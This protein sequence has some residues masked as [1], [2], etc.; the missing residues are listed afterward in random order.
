M[1]LLA[2]VAGC[3]SLD[4][5]NKNAPE[6]ERA[7]SDPQTIV[8][9]AAGTMKSYINLRVNYEPALAP[10]STQADEHS[11]SWNNFQSRYYSSYGVE[12][13]ERCGWENNTTG[14]RY[15]PLPFWWYGSYAVVSAAND[16]L[17]A[18]R[19]SAAPPDLGT[20][21]PWV[22]A[23]AQM[24]QGLG[25]GLVALTYDQGFVV[26]ESAHTVDELAALQLVS[27]TEVRDAAL[28][29][30]D[31]AAVLAAAADFSAAP[32]TLFGLPT[33]PRY[34]SAQIVQIIRTFEAELLAMF[35]RT[36]DEDAAVPWARVVSYA[37][38]GISSGTAFN[39]E[40]FQGNITRS[41]YED[42]FTGIDQWGNDY[43]TT[44]IDTRVARLLSTT[45][46]DPWPGG[47][48]N[49]RPADGLGNPIGGVYGVDR[50][51]GDGCF[52]A[53]ANRFG[54]G[55]CKA[56]A[57]SGT[58][59]MWSPSADFPASRGQFHQSNIGY[60]RN[61]CL[62]S[63]FDDCPNGS[64][65]FVVLSKYA[66]DLLWAEGLLRTTGPS[67]T[68]AALINNSHVGRG[69]LLPVSAVDTKD[70][71]LKALFYEWHAE[72]VSMAPDHFWNAR[73]LTKT[74]LI[75]AG[76]NPWAVN[77]QTYEPEGAYVW[78]PLWGGTPRSMPIPAKDLILLRLELYTFGG[79]SDP[80]GCGATGGPS[81]SIAA[82]GP[83]VKNVRQIYA[84]LKAM[85]PKP[86]TRLRQ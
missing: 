11:F 15:E 35:P 59:F 40:A 58:D 84:D 76:A 17:F 62:V 60:I 44:R 64:G 81:C 61:H 71:L 82:D 4:I 73:R 45:Q 22:E 21:A 39:F 42:F 48:G 49:P 30:L 53:V 46:Q 68:V 13:P 83:A 9:T 67:V 24:A 47:A 7:F 1:A 69:G 36:A 23:V 12:C 14:A 18:I 77:Q 66:N 79:P 5:V 74:S 72:L 56:T 3:P 75:S 41:G 19:K 55:E 33:G 10:F 31:S 63:G 38:R 43:T 27:R 52:G 86:G 78:N 28:A 51:L 80:L 8:A 85:M 50:R 57:N 37:S 25:H 70:N 34:T 20:D 2:G 6:R 54:E 29:Q 16:V 65:N 26:P 32:A